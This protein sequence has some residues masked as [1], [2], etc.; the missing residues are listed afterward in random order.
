MDRNQTTINGF[1]REELQDRAYLHYQLHW[2]MQNNITPLELFLSVALFGS[3]AENLKVSDLADA[4]AMTDLFGEWE[5]LKGWNGLIWITK[6]T[7][8]E[9]TYRN[10]AYASYIKDLLPP[11]EYGAW[12][13]FR[14]L[15]D[16]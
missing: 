15:D 12:E 9:H 1:T 16:D 13:Q 8:L 5:A 10:N 6:D 11:D 3:D 2:M 14:K 4:D 7:F